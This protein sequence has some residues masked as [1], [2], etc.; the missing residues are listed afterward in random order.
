MGLQFDAPHITDQSWP[1]GY[2]YFVARLDG[3]IGEGKSSPCQSHLNASDCNEDFEYNC[4][5]YGEKSICYETRA[6]D[7]GATTNNGVCSLNSNEA[8]CIQVKTESGETCTWYEGGGKAM[9]YDK[10]ALKDGSYDKAG[11]FLATEESGGQWHI[12]DQLYAPST[13]GN[14]ILQWRWDNEQTP[15]IWTTCADISVVENQSS[16]VAGGRASL[17]VSLGMV[18]SLLVMVTLN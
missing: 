4:Q 3:K 18:M 11:R 9:C 2:G 12:T 16:D 13:P 14:Y 8:S 1:E 6:K 17:S 5:W 15:Q 10:L 7:K